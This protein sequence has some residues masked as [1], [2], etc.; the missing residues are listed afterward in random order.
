M[1]SISRLAEFDKSSPS[2]RLLIDHSEHGGPILDA[3]KAA[4]DLDRAMGGWPEC[5]QCGARFQPRANSGG[6]TQLYCS[7]ACRTAFHAR[8]RA[9]AP[10][11]PVPSQR[12]KPHVG[13]REPE[14]TVPAPEPEEAP[15]DAPTEEEFDWFDDPDVVQHHQRAVAV[16][17]NADDNISIRGESDLYDNDDPVIVI[18]RVNLPKF[19]GRLQ[20]IQNEIEKENR[21]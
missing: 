17:R 14:P 21:R 6:K 4:D 11:M 3:S 19:I 18:A 15:D 10:E 13:V 12:R 8:D 16:Y 20:S 1:N 5:R 7:P 9:P 2:P